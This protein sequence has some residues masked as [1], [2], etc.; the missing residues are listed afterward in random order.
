MLF[1]Q[2]FFLASLKIKKRFPK[3]ALVGRPPN[4]VRP[5]T[6]RLLCTSRLA[7]RTGNSRGRTAMKLRAVLLAGL[8]GSTFLAGAALAA[9]NILT[10]QTAA[11]E[12]NRA[13][14]QTLLNSP[15]KP[16]VAGA[17]GTAALVWAAS[18]NDVEMA[19]M[20]LRA[21]ANAKGANEF[22]ATAVYAAAAHA[23]PALLSK[24]L[25]AGAD[26]NIAIVSGE[27]PLMMAARRG[28]L[29]AVRA[30]LAAGAKPNAAENN[31]G[32]TALMM[33]IV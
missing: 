11:K 32:Q 9:E 6:N 13:A 16:N 21:G 7:T 5:A 24:L 33:A 8:L 31:A 20:L 10:L 4:G 22:G 27:T 12:G 19:D 14:V 23:N 3:S 28:N 1:A 25:S 30:L 2:L 26:P 17:E 15:V 29:E 18:R